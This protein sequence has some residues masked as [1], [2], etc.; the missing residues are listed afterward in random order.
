MFLLLASFALLSALAAPLDASPAGV[1][2]S[3]SVATRLAHRMRAD[4]EST[5]ASSEM[6]TDSEAAQSAM[7]AYIIDVVNALP[8][9]GWTA[10]VNEYFQVQSGFRMH[11]GVYTVS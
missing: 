9:A 8:N 1:G 5:P 3:S 6:E 7:S 2:S 4:S 11:T 10:G